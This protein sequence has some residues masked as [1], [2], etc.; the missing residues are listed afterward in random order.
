MTL[1]NVGIIKPDPNQPRRTFDAEKMAA[2][3]ASIKKDGFR[4]EYPILVD[5]DRVIVDG[6]RRWRASKKAGL[7]KVPVIIK[8]NVSESERLMY[9]LQ[10]E[11]AELDKR[12][13]NRAWV[14]LWELA[15]TQMTKT[16]I[17]KALGVDHKTYGLVLSNHYDAQKLLDTLGTQ[18]LRR[19]SSKRPEKLFAGIE[20][21]SLSNKDKTKMAEKATEENWDEVRTYEIRRAIEEKPLSAKKILSHDYSDKESRHWK[22]TLE[23]AKAGFSNEE[24]EELKETA[25]SHDAMEEQI[26]AFMDIF[27]YGLKLS[28]AL[29]KFDYTKVTPAKRTELHRKM[30]KFL[31]FVNGY[32]KE[33]ETYMIEM[34]ELQRNH[35]LSN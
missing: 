16:D 11:G 32:I 17:A 1:F 19:R 12:E 21:S 7:K 26:D 8:D 35:K 22:T 24:A 30:Y 3:V 6:E 28:A 33:L 29:R 13:R 15:Q 9:Q 5:S 10:S 2:L 4:E 31:P 20:R 18:S 14:R 34:G 27:T 25:K 23:V